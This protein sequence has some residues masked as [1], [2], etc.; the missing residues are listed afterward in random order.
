M[1][2]VPYVLHYV[3]NHLCALYRNALVLHEKHHQRK[4]QR[5]I[6]TVNAS[7]VFAL[8]DIHRKHH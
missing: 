5:V 7:G 8:V 4:L 2:V 6:T 1:Q 3:P